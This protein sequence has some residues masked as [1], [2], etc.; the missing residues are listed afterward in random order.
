MSKTIKGNKNEV[1]INSSNTQNSSK[2]EVN[3]LASNIKRLREKNNLTQRGLCEK[4]WVSYTTLT[5]I[6]I[7]VIKEPSV[8]ICYE[9]AKALWVGIEELI[10]EN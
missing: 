3:F 4:S 2:D 5:K 8:Y 9:L 6:E 7:W 1:K 10:L